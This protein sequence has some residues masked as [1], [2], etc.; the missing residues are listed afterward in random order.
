MNKLFILAFTVISINSMAIEFIT[1]AQVGEILEAS[2]VIEISK[3][4]V[5]TLLDSP[6]KCALDFSS[7][8]ARTYVVKKGNDAFLYLTKEGLQDLTLC[9]KL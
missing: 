3:Y 6:N 4:S 7:R 8:S 5:E 2:K 9:R 1:E